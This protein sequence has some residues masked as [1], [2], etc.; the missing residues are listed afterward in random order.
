MIGIIDC[1]L[2]NIGSIKNM[3]KKTGCE[4]A[5]VIKEPEMLFRTDKIILPGVGAFDTGMRLLNYSGMRKG[6]DYLV[7]DR[8]IPILGICL[9]MQMFG[10]GSQEGKEEGLGY[11]NMECYKFANETAENRILKIPHMGWDYVEIQGKSKL[12]NGLDSKQERYYFVHSY[13]VKCQNKEDV[14][15][16]CHYGVDFAAAVNHENIYG[17]QFHP[18][19]SHKYGMKLLKNFLEL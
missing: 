9:G 15:M 10:V 8:K 2:G 12:M 11:I 19:K 7:K 4:N 13:Y 18:E 3:L 5:E 6:L 16:T 1:G 14:Q 17:V